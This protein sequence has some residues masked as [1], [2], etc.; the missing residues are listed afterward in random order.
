MRGP[1]AVAEWAVAWA[2]EAN[3]E[4]MLRLATLFIAVLISTTAQGHHWVK[5][6]YDSTQRFIIEVEVQ[7]FQLI[8]PHPL[9]LVEI[10]AIPEQESAGDLEIGQ[11]WTLEM[12]NRREL[13]ALGWHNET[14]VPGDQIT[15]V[16]NPSQTSLYRENTLYMRAA[17]HRREGFVYL[18][19]VRRLYPIDSEGDNLSKHLD[20]IN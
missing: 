14:F 13:T 18:H 10:I 19:N 17:Q 15:V 3:S 20:E 5:D 6:V 2:W 8:H 4:S 11:T 1:R 9:M 7:K 16:V 12:D